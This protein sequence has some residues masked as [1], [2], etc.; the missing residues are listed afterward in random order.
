[1]M[2][3]LRTSYNEQNLVPPQLWS[4]DLI[5]RMIMDEFFD[6]R[7]LST[8]RIN[9]GDAPSVFRCATWTATPDTTP[10]AAVNNSDMEDIDMDETSPLL[11]AYASEK[12]HKSQWPQQPV[13]TLDEESQRSHP[14][15]AQRRVAS[16]ILG[17]FSLACSLCFFTCVF[18]F[19]NSD[20]TGVQ[21]AVTA[22]GDA[23][24]RATA[25][26]AYERLLPS[27]WGC[28]S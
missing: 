12:A 14:R 3:P 5:D 23:L 15:P 28:L 6:N 22:Q 24:V 2:N 9:N 11:S 1:M 21:D 10:H 8:Y 16:E 27:L 17:A 26:Y 25:S 20:D 18:F 7:L 13:A 4:M 19:A